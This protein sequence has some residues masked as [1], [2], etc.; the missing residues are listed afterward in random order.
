MIGTEFRLRAG[1]RGLWEQT[2][3]LVDDMVV[4]ARPQ[5]VDE[6]L[7]ILED[8]L[9]CHG[10][11]SSRDKCTALCR[12]H[13]PDER[14]KS[15]QQSQVAKAV[16]S[17]H[18][19]SS[20]TWLG[21]FGVE[22]ETARTW[23]ETAKKSV[24]T[25]ATLVEQGASLGQLA[26]QAA[27]AMPLHRSCAAL[28]YD[29]RVLSSA[30]SK[31]L[32]QDLKRS[33]LHAAASVISVPTDFDVE[34]QKQASLP[35]Y[36]GGG[37]LVCHE[38]L[39]P[40]YRVAA[41]AQLLPVARQLIAATP[42]LPMEETLLAIPSDDIEECMQQLV[43]SGIKVSAD[44]EIAQG[45]EQRLDFETNFRSIAGLA[46]KLSKVVLSQLFDE[47]ILEYETR[48]DLRSLARLRSSGGT[49]AEWVRCVPSHKHVSLSDAG[50]AASMRWRLG[51]AVAPINARCMKKAVK[52]ATGATKCCIQVQPLGDHALLC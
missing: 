22:A 36:L 19:A 11:V 35:G 8:T 32:V 21:P 5:D 1:E 30:Q 17:A 9:R 20:E 43:S 46:G 31:P 39:V 51:C 29:T 15:Q 50:F 13:G 38:E 12:D 47:L 34:T 4:V 28:A 25:I 40:G 37:G 49:G 14:I 52:S 48:R 6:L 18:N 26:K 10:L 41:A 7:G 24:A 3:S 2:L 16:V 27:S 42:S 23:L 44:G 45:K 33:I